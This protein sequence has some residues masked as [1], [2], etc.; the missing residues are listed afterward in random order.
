MP[1][2][3]GARYE[4]KSPS[5]LVSSF[6]LISDF[7]DF[8]CGLPL[9]TKLTRIRTWFAFQ[10]T[11]SKSVACST[12]TWLSITSETWLT[13]AVKVS[14]NINTGCIFI[15]IMDVVAAFIDIWIVGKETDRSRTTEIKGDL[16]L[17]TEWQNKNLVPRTS[18]KGQN[19]HHKWEI[20]YDGWC[21]WRT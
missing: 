1:I 5:V 8:P 3:D 15:A 18:I 9:K 20:W 17:C 21:L 13:Y 12:W 2:D 6:F 7:Q 11:L 19:G 14:G 10:Y 4:F 16:N